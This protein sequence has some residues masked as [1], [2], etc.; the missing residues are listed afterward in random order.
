LPLAGKNLMYE[1]KEQQR[2][3]LAEVLAADESEG[4]EE[5]LPEDADDINRHKQ[6]RRQTSNFIIIIHLHAY[7]TLVASAKTISGAAELSYTEVRKTTTKTESY[8]GQARHPIF[9][10]RAKMR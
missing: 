7:Y 5:E 10:Q 6:A 8:R 4:R 3:L 1:T 9:K 2:E